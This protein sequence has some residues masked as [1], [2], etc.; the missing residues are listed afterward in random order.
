MKIEVLGSG[1]ATCKK[2]HEI[3]KWVVKN[4]KLD[5]EVEYP[6]DIRKIVELGL[7]KSPI[8]VVDGKPVDIQSTSEK[9]V[10][11]ALSGAKAKKTD[12][13]ATCSCNGNC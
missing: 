1:C 13:G 3:V 10:R 12:D 5:A 8:L 4:D 6:D 9:D 7:M 11:Q 2:L